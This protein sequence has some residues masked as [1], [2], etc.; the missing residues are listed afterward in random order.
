MQDPE[1]VKDAFSGIAKK[2]V[3]TNHI[4]SLGIDILW[5]RKVAKVVSKKKPNRIL[6]LATGSG[7]LALEIEK[8]SSNSEIICSDFCAPMLEIAESRG[9]KT[10]LADAMSLP[11][12]DQDFDLISVGF[13]LRNMADWSD[14]LHEMKR[15]LKT[16]GYIVILDFSLPDNKFRRALYCIYL[17]K[18]L[19]FIAGVI[20]RKR[21][22][23]KYLAKTIEEFPSGK[24]MC[25]FIEGNGFN[26][27]KCYPLSFGIA[28]IY[29]ARKPE[30]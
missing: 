20:T 8:K 4:L 18:I 17:N 22:A 27:A 14:A 16:N 26:E 28:S 13:G 2:Y 5:R 12:N 7:D 1:Y 30:K 15:V 9:L 3:I 6:D 10:V 25:D 21:A 23:Y 19:P 11:F 24:S 29:I